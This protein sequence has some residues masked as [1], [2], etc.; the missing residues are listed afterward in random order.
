MCNTGW[1]ACLPVHISNLT[2]LKI[3]IIMDIFT[4]VKIHGHNKLSCIF[5]E[6]SKHEGWAEGWS[7]NPGT[8]HLYDETKYLWFFLSCW[9]QKKKE[10]KKEKPPHTSHAMSHLTNTHTHIFP[11]SHH[12]ITL[13]LI[14]CSIRGI[15]HFVVFICLLNVPNL[16]CVCWP[17]VI[18]INF[19][20]NSFIWYGDVFTAVNY[21]HIACVFTSLKLQFNCLCV[22]VWC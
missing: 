8:R 15:F 9:T 11:V 2:A 19:L 22:L 7:Y 20:S 5:S 17:S 3:A 6:F 13:Y 21:L 16:F 14:H 12:Q 4:E 1:K 18:M 10:R